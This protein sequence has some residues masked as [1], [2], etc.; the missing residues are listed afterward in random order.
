MLASA[1][2]KRAQS[3]KMADQASVYAFGSAWSG[4]LRTAIIYC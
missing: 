3:D 2:E 1:E 4:A